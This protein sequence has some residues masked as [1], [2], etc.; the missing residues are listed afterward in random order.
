MALCNLLD[1]E[2]TQMVALLLFFLAWTTAAT[3]GGSQS[4]NTTLVRRFF[5]ELQSMR[6]AELVEELF[7][8]SAV[9]NGMP[10]DID[11]MKANLIRADPPF[12]NFRI[13]IEELITSGDTAVAKTK[14]SG[15][16]SGTWF[17][18]PPTGKVATMDASDIFTFRNGKIV[19][20]WHI[21]DRLGAMVQLAGLPLSPA[22][23]AEQPA[24]TIMN[25]ERA[26]SDAYLRH[27]TKAIAN[28]L[29]HDFVGIDG[30]GFLSDK[31]AELNEADAPATASTFQILSENY[32]DMQVR[33]FG[34]TAVLTDINHVKGRIGGKDVARRYRR[35][36]VWVKREGRW[37]C[38]S[39]HA[40][41]IL[42]P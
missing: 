7:D 2:S 16:Q 39:F 19:E 11:R 20:Q 25:L 23:S 6:R 17:G 5:E 27:D 8:H 31:S 32:S 3:P 42:E 26:W 38:V 37:Q 12:T 41:Q 9:I 28:I 15:I 24:E 10:I 34:S 40:S 33:V 18:L 22:T 35:T 1:T 30:R 4:T 36:T 29:A 14:G 13:R 21:A